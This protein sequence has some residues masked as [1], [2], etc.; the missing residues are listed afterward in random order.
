MKQAVFLIIMIFMVMWARPAACADQGTDIPGEVP[1]DHWSYRE[2]ADLGI[3]YQ[4]T[5]KLPDLPVVPRQELDE[6]FLKILEK[7]ALKR[8]A[9][10]PGAIP[11]E[12]RQRLAT[13]NAALQADLKA[14]QA[15]VTRQDTFEK[16]LE[17]PEEQSYLY[18]VGVKGFLSGEGTANFAFSDFSYTPGH[19]VGLLLYR[20]KPYLEWRPTDWLEVEVDGQVYGYT[21]NPQHYNRFSLYQAYLELKPPA[22]RETA[23]QDRPAGV[24]LRERLHPWRQQLLRRIDLRC[25]PSPAQADL[26]IHAG[27]AGGE[28][29]GTLYPLL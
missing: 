13:L 28:L 3:K 26:G 9:E 24:R 14:N 4:V 22:I 25:G 21:F 17:P 1:R 12:D 6:V 10:G 20:I 5:E 27:P 16:I 19:G 15:Y 23:S 8:E 29:C 18:K 11:R 2:V 7:V